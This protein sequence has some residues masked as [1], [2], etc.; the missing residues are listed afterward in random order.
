MSKPLSP[1]ERAVWAAAYVASSSG[2]LVRAAREAAYAVRRLRRG[3][4]AGEL[5]V[6]DMAMLDDILGVAERA[7]D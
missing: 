4:G 2:G 5:D 3:I 6:D 7:D 1:G